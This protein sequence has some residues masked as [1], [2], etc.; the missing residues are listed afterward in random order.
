MALLA[1]VCIGLMLM[2]WT[3]ALAGSTQDYHY[4]GDI[5]RYL[6]TISHGKGTLFLEPAG[7]IPY[8]SGLR[9]D[10]EIGLVSARVTDY[11][12][13]DPDAWWFDYV[14]TQHPDYIVE[15]QSF[16]QYRTIEGY[17]LTPD[18]QRWFEAHYQLLRRVHYEPA[19]YHPSPLLQRILAMGP[20]EDYLIYGRRDHLR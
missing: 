5:G 9:T 18:Q 6:A 1:V 14:A 7:L 17:T 19:T 10:D 13:R 11:M 3:K 8:F 15:R 12:R 4:R 16:D 20:L 2:Q